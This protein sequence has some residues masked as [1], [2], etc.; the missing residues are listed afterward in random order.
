MLKKLSRIKGEIYKWKIRLRLKDRQLHTHIEATAEDAASIYADLMGD[1][2]REKVGLPAKAAGPR[3]TLADAAI[4][5]EKHLHTVKKSADY[6][7][8]VVYDLALL[9]KLLK[10]DCQLSRITRQQVNEWKEARAACVYHKRLVKPRTVNKGL[11]QLSA[12]FNFCITERGW[13][14]D[15]PAAETAL[16][17]E[18]APPLRV[19]SWADYLKFSEAA[20]ARPCFGWLVEVAGE[21]GARIDEVMRAKVGDVNIGRQ[22]W[23]K[24]VKPGRHVTIDA[25]EWVL[26]AAK[27]R[28]AGEWLCP[29]EGNRQWTY[30]MIRKAFATANKAAGLNITP[31]FLR[32]G[33]ACWLLA[34]GVSIYEVQK[35]LGHVSVT[36]TEIYTKAAS[37]LRRE[38][39]V[40]TIHKNL[41]R[42]CHKNDTF[43]TSPLLLATL[44]NVS[45]SRCK[46]IE[47]KRLNRK[48]V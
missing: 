16:I 30:S 17:K 24:V 28:T 40:G 47:A 45:K 10:D 34:E 48:V 2:A 3:I 9:R 36:T 39:S 21:T 26:A 31:H 44:H 4:Q 35:L 32:H 20:W 11:R 42:L 7:A 46:S 43:G 41:S 29:A 15:N 13:I 18:I 1:R 19:L 5:Y 38:E 33:R 8:D 6:V 22:T 23:E 12:F 27:D 37:E 25:K 14:R